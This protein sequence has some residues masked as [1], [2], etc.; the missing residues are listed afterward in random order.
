MKKLFCILLI[1][2]LLISALS[3]CS[4]I[5]DFV[6]DYE[7][8]DDIIITEDNENDTIIEDTDKEEIKDEE[9]DETEQEESKHSVLS[10][11]KTPYNFIIDSKE[12]TLPIKY[13][14]LANMINLKSEENLNK[15]IT[16]HDTVKIPA[17]INDLEVMLTINCFEIL[18]GKTKLTDCYVTG[19]SG[20][21]QDDIIFYKQITNKTSMREVKSIYGD[22][23]FENAGL[24]EL[25]VYYKLP[26]CSYDSYNIGIEFIFDMDGNMKSFNYGD[27]NKDYIEYIEW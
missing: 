2:F 25:L 26:L 4:F 23:D 27:T 13:S 5:E 9:S 10:Q 8:A 21:A 17:K 20:T 14:E 18:G 12:I 19:I 16:S 1:S 7:V 11:D 3:G 24:E 6:D 22:G 15:E